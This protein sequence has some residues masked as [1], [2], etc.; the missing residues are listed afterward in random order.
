[1]QHPRPIGPINNIAASFGPEMAQGSRP[2]RSRA[3][4]APRIPLPVSQTTHVAA[5]F[6][7]EMSAGSRPDRN[8]AFVPPKIGWTVSQTI[9]EIFSPDMVVGSLP[10]RNR[11]FIAPKVGWST[12]QTT[13]V[14][15]AFSIEMA[16]GTAQPRF[17]YRAPS[18]Q[19]HQWWT[20]EVEAFGIEQVLGSKPDRNRQRLGPRIGQPSSQVTHTAA[21]FSVEMA[22]GAIPLQARQRNDVRMR[23]GWVGPTNPGPDVSPVVEVTS[24]PHRYLWESAHL[25]AQPWNGHLRAIEW[26]AHPWRVAAWDPHLRLFTWTFHRRDE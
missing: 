25:R 7:P 9:A 6:S 13:P 5:A 15:A 18:H 11:A 24:G 12:S 19:G 26:S 22:Q 10:S 14:D 17:R 8:R 4:L 20:P 21:P 2:D 1:M 3:F 23:S 16:Q